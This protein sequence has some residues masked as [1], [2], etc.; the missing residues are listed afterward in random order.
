VP[1]IHGHPQTIKDVRISGDE[2]KSKQ[3]NSLK[4]HY[5]KTPYFKEYYPLLEEAITFNHELL[6]GLNLHLI[7]AV[8]DA[9]GI[10]AKMM[11]S[12]EFP[13][14]GEEK[15]EKLV[16]M[17]KFLGADTYLSGSGGQNYI[18]EELFS[19]AGISLQWH[20]YEHPT[21]AQIWGGFK[22][23]MSIVDL[24]FNEGPNAKE[25]LLRGG[26]VEEKKLVQAQLAIQQEPVLELHNL[27]VRNT[28][29]F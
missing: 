22:P 9:L 12:S 3:I 23:N 26:K 18:K 2:W 4:A 24:L 15:N 6:I 16:S 27:G 17:C 20:S 29:D 10:K 13:Y 1:I 11:R 21:Y 25:I 8:A 19:Q 28:L 7:K 5:R 14:G